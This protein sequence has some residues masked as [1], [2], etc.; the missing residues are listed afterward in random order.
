MAKNFFYVFGEIGIEDGG[1][2][3]FLFVGFGPCDALGD[4]AAHWIGGVKHCHRT[5][6]VLD[7]DLGASADASQQR[8]KIA[9][10]INLGDVNDI[11]SHGTIIHR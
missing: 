10:C 1:S 3:G 5:L 11:L 6:T 7:D 2:A 4:A 8:G 9:S